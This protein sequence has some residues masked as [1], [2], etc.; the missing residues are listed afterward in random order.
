MLLTLLC[1]V[2]A[3]HKGKPDAWLSGQSIAVYEEM[4]LV[5]VMSL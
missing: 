2:S 5:D 4:K 3:N 1:A